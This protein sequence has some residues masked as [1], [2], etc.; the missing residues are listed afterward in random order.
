[1]KVNLKD[2]I[3]RYWWVDKGDSFGVVH[4]ETKREGYYYT[5]RAYIMQTGVYSENNNVIEIVTKDIFVTDQPDVEVT[6]QPVGNGLYRA[7]DSIYVPFT[8]TYIAKAIE[9]DGLLVHVRS[10]GVNYYLPAVPED[11][12]VIYVKFGGSSTSGVS[13]AMAYGSAYLANGLYPPEWASAL[14]VVR[15]VHFFLYYEHRSG[16]R[17][18]TY[19]RDNATKPLFDWVFPGHAWTKAVSLSDMLYYVNRALGRNFK[20]RDRNKYFTAMVSDFYVNAEGGV[21]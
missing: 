14:P 4:I 13:S 7:S 8:G 11:N 18:Q 6:L 20:V 17:L 2:L 16:T 19:D 1:M 21:L 10:A 15:P 12:A 9:K 3:R 5:H